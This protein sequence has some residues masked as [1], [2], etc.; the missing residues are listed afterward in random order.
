MDLVDFL[1]SNWAE[2]YGMSFEECFC[3]LEWFAMWRYI[4][5]CLNSTSSI[6]QHRNM[7]STNRVW[8]CPCTVL[9]TRQPVCFSFQT[10]CQPVL[11]THKG[12]VPEI[13]FDF[14]F[15]TWTEG[16]F[17]IAD[18]NMRVHLFLLEL[19]S[20]DMSLIICF[21]LSHPYFFLFFFRIMCETVRY[22]RHE[23]NEV[24][25]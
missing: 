14:G 5:V 2:L 1:L 4:R 22:E 24:L 25:Y 18:K 15:T 3:P 10:Q 16:F 19:L 12:F 11:N 21:S 23:A 17:I 8:F 13:L 7:S 20:L 9:N 6:N